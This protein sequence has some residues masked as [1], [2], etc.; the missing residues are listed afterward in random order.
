VSLYNY[1]DACVDALLENDYGVQNDPTGN[2]WAACVQFA[3]VDL[4]GAERDEE[5]PPH[6]ALCTW[7]DGFSCDCEASR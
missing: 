1:L 2:V 5:M 6:D 4:A 7:H 3:N